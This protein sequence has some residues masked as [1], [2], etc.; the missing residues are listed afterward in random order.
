MCESFKRYFS[1][2]GTDFGGKKT[3]KKVKLKQPSGE[4]ENEH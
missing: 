1:T 2:Y 3:M 4:R